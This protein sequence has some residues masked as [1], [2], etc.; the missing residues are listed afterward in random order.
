MCTFTLIQLVNSIQSQAGID[1]KT[2]Y[3]WWCLECIDDEKYFS[4]SITSI[5]KFVEEELCVTFSAGKV[6]IKKQINKFKELIIESKIDKCENV[7]TIVDVRI[8]I[9]RIK[10]D[11]NECK[12]KM[13]EF[14]NIWRLSRIL[15]YQKLSHYA[16]WHL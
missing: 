13:F 9:R 5:N 11:A 7:E 15:H 16:W 2:V 10:I 6:W 14:F 4:N 1:W 12:G 8:K 3:K